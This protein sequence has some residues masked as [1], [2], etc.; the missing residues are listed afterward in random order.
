M[1]WTI[2]GGVVVGGVALFVLYYVFELAEAA[3]EGAGY[4]LLA[5]LLV[6]VAAVTAWR[7]HSSHRPVRPQTAGTRSSEVACT[8]VVDRPLRAA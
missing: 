5:F 6:V 8:R 7:V 4:R 2:V 1:I 3:G